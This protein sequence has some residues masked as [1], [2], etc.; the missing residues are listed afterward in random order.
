MSR[1]RFLVAF[2]S[3]AAAG[4]AVVPSDDPRP[5]AEDPVCLYNRDLGCIRVRIDDDTPHATHHGTT[6]YFCAVSCREEFEADPE[7]YLGR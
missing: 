1:I 6:Y 3:I 2:V 7:K 4:C 5:V